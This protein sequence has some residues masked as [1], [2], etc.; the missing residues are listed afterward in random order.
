MSQAIEGG[1]PADLVEWLSGG[2]IVVVATVDAEGWPYTMIMNWAVA[3]DETIVRLSIDRRT[4]T[5]KNIEANGR[6]MIEVLGDGL[7]YAVRGDARVILDVMEHAP[8]PSAMVEVKVN[9]V[10]KDLVPGV[11]FEGPKFHWGALE[12]VMSKADPLG[13][14][15]LHSYRLS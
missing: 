3:V 4:T 1:M 8:I 10:K 6:V 2:K 7:A 14:A 13:I 5:L 12:P 15:E 11:E 9:R